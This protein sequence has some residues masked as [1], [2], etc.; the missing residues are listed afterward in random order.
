[1]KDIVWDDT[2][3]VEIDEIDEDH[4]RLTDLFNMLNHSVESSDSRDYIEALLEELISCTIWHFR[5]EERLMLKYQ[6][7]N[8]ESHKSEHQE[9]VEGV[10]ELQSKF[11]SEDRVPSEEDLQYLELWL[12]RHILSTDMELGR[13]LINNM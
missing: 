6:Y 5:H 11:Q 9:L 10:R 7:E 3:S 13:Y 2:L 12:T 8:F 1:M 4:R